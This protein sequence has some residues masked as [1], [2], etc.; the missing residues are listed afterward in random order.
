MYTSIAS[1]QC[2]YSNAGRLQRSSLALR[3]GCLPIWGRASLG[4]TPA[5][6][7]GAAPVHL[8]EGPAEAAA[9]VAAAAVAE[10]VAVLVVIRG[11]RDGRR[12]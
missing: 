9:A 3:R 12:I 4:V 11:G 1:R 6:A 10:A 7:L 5:G 2:Y 8:A